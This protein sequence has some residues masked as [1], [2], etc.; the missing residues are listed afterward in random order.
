MGY[1]A[2]NP[3]RFLGTSVGS[4]QCVAYVQAA[5]L[6]GQT[7]G[8]ARGELVKDAKLA[9]GTAIACNNDGRNYHVIA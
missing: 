2:G 4:G 3:K 7:R 8:W 1:I 6:T 9:I 5:A